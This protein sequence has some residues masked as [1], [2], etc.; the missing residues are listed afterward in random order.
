MIALQ[1]I[2]VATDSSAA[3]DAAAEQVVLRDGS[4]A[5][6]RLAVPGDHGEVARFFHRLSL[7]SLRLRFFG[8]AEPSATLLDTFCVSSHPDQAAT[9]LALRPVDGVPYAIAVASYF[10]IDAATAEVAFAVDDHLHHNGLGTMLL[11]RLATLAR[12]QGFTTFEAVTL[13]DN[14]PMLDMFRD[15]G[16]AMRV[17]PERGSV[18]VQLS[19]DRAAEFP[20]PRCGEFP[21]PHRR[22]PREEV[23]ASENLD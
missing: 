20:A 3:S 10:R 11:H 19:L 8:P 6:L 9:M 12:G 13:P 23:I 1:T 7:D 14:V 4:V 15:S 16:F 18:T 5:Q 22:A 2:L 17:K 21:A